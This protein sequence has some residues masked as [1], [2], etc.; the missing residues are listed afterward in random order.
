MKINALLQDEKFNYFFSLIL[1]IGIICVIRPMC[2]GK[3][4]ASVKPPMEKD[5]GKYVYR[6]ADKCYEFKT[7]TLHCPS[8]GAI[9]AFHSRSS[10]TFSRR[11]SPIPKE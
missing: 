2:S 7:K 4:C 10:D 6:L 8:T 3:E 5:F 1:G 9:E 11:T